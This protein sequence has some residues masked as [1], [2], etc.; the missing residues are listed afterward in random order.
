LFVGALVPGKG[1]NVLSE[2][3]QKLDTKTKLVLIGGKHPD[4][5]YRSTKDILVIEDAPHD[6]VMQAMSRCRFA[7]FPSIWPEPFGTVAIEAM[8]QKKAVI[9]CD[10]GGLK[11]VVVDKQTGILVPPKDADKLTEAISY[12]QQSP[13]TASEMGQRGYERWRKNYTSE[14]VIPRIIDVYQSL[15]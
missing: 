7:V 6:V 11:S 4:Y 9:A 10:V 2:A 3:F 14:A 5:Q 15:N 1:I 13:D 8:S 12:L